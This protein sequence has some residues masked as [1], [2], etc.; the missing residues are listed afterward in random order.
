[1]QPAALQQPNSAKDSQ[2]CDQVL[3]LECICIS[4]HLSP[5]TEQKP[6]VGSG[7]C[8]PDRGPR[9]ADRRRK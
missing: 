8:N 7:Q 1:M 9:E 2:I 3:P 5:A 4:Q 6:K